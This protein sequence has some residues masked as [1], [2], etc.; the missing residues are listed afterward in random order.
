MRLLLMSVMVLSLSAQANDKERAL[1]SIQD[2]IAAGDLSKAAFLLVQA[3]EKQ[4]EDAGLLNLRGVVHAQQNEFAG[5]RSDFAKAV[6]LDPGLLPAW[7]NL[8]RVCQMEPV[9]DHDAVD[10]AQNSWRRVVRA[11]PADGEARRGLALALE[12]ASKFAESL[13][14][15]GKAG[16][17][18]GDLIVRCLDLAGLKRDSEALL[19]AKK[20]AAMADLSEGDL[21]L[22][23]AAGPQVTIVLGDA[24][25]QRGGLSVE[26]LKSLA[27]A[28]ERSARLQEAR[29]TLERIALAEPQNAAHLL[30]VARV[31]EKQAD[32]EGAL[33][34]L[35]HA[36]ELTPQDARVHFLFGMVAAEMNLPVEARRS[37]DKALEMDPANA[38][39][40]YA[41]GAI[42][43]TTRD[44]ATAASYFAKFIAVRPAEAKGH[45]ALGVA[46]FTSGDYAKAK[47]ELEPVKADAVVG[48]GA[49]FFLGRIARLEGDLD[50]AKHHLA[51]AIRMMPKFAESHTELARVAMLEGRL[52]VAAD[53]L[54]LALKL[55][56]K[57]FQANSQLLVLYKRTHDAREHQQAELLKQ[58]DEDRSRRAEL[59]LRTVEIRP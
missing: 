58:L 37:F 15:L 55:D 50:G 3:L 27:I 36:R 6:K 32:H 53:E 44:A 5:A 31:A 33:G 22:M 47:A 9:Q 41:M 29:K 56:E 52:D 12:R 13:E 48:G 4:P 20:L 2:A 46:E 8:G 11:L 35:G 39:Y 21:L 24:L 30:E 23:S 19:V 54:K 59:M 7:R 10:C 43:L 28:Y 42:I 1:V 45:Y 49:E 38:D 17:S 51:I 26:G 34:Y 25:D 57:S 16:A 14:M 40:N 18:I